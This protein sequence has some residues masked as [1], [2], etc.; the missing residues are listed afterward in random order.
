[1]RA[2]LKKSQAVKIILMVKLCLLSLFLVMPL[3]TQ[4][5]FTF[6]TNADGSLNISKYTGAGGAVVIPP[7]R[8]AWPSPPSG[9]LHF[10]ITAP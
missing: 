6:T 10:L 4:A 1:M 5:Q 7:G 8:M 2:C 3:M 9:T